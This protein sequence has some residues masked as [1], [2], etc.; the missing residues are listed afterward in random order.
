MS[1]TATTGSRSARRRA[2]ARLRAWLTALSD[3]VH[4]AGDD[5]ARALG[6]AVTV[7]PGP[8][9]L[10]GRCYRHPGFGP[11]PRGPASLPGPARQPEGST[12]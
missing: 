12:R 4:A 11:G 8:A 7:V 1:T 6:W 9:G 5:R 10:N 2:A 3:R